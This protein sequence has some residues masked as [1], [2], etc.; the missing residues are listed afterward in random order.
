M[1]ETRRN[2]RLPD[3]TGQ[4]AA[5]DSGRRRQRPQKTSGR[6]DERLQSGMRLVYHGR[7]S[8]SQ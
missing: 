4:A 7:N 6:E 3:A 5:E 8:A 2:I 1:A